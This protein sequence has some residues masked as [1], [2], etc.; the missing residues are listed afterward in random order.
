METF[1]AGLAAFIGLLVW[2][3]THQQFKLQL[4]EKRWAIYVRMREIV[5]EF[6]RHAHVDQWTLN[7]FARLRHQ[8]RY[9]FG[10]KFPKNLKAFEDDMIEAM[11][12]DKAADSSDDNEK[13]LLK[14]SEHFRDAVDFIKFES[15]FN[16]GLSVDDSPIAWLANWAHDR[17]KRSEL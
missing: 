2:F 5:A 1:V 3:T 13:L 10:R 14:Q 7:E 11:R 9:L 17:F 6:A 15:V 16:R 12:L 8:A 4:F